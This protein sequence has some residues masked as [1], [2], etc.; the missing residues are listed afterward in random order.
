M[1]KRKIVYITISI[2]AVLF[3][4]YWIGINILVSA[5]LV[6]SFMRK[7][8]SFQE[9]TDKSYSEQ[10][11][12]TDLKENLKSGWADTREWLENNPPEYKA[13]MSDDGYK[14]IGAEFDNDRNNHKWVLMLHGYT[15]WKEEMY[16]Y[17]YDYY[18][19]GFS[20]FVPDL[21]CQGSSEGDFIGM[22]YTDSRDC[23]LWIRLILKMDPEAEIVIHGQSMGA[24]T[25]LMMSGLDLPENVKC[26]V[27]DAAYTDAYS[28]F[29]DKI[30][31]W[32]GLP[33]FPFVDSAVLCLKL[34]GGYDLKKAS[35]LDAVKT[36][37]TPTLFIHGDEDRM[38]SVDMAYELYEAENAEKQ[39]YIIPGAGHAQC[40]DKNPEEF[41]QVIY[42]FVMK[43]IREVPKEN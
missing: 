9:I 38:I 31:D 3:I 39:L 18:K 35:A 17:A 20:I 32:F 2:L 6:P 43:N 22:G 28:M 16:I 33:P 5:C 41:T 4:I 26:I 15:G 29:G 13:V 30:T 37:K 40:R 14:L 34:R 12:T 7:L 27:S 23:L 24:A 10:V 36:S 8:D 1:K 11:Q 19:W 21:R 25:A 42:D